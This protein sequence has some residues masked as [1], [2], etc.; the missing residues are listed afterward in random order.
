MTA[1]EAATVLQELAAIGPVKI[2]W[3][4]GHTDLTNYEFAD[5]LTCKD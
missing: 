4:K 2:K 1:L 3:T 5:E